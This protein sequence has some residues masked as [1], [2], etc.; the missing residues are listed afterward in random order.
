MQTANIDEALRTRHMVWQK[1]EPQCVYCLSFGVNRI[2]CLAQPAQESQL[3]GQGENGLNVWVCVYGEGGWV[4]VSLR[5]KALWFTWL[6]AA[7]KTSN[8]ARIFHRC[9]VKCRIIWI[10]KNR[11]HSTTLWPATQPKLNN[12][13]SFLN[14][15]SILET[16][17]WEVGFLLRGTVIGDPC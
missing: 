13:I 10:C 9:K 2:I 7:R 16:F 6:V 15:F 1:Y 12:V 4:D 5:F 8:H 17:P 3:T 14:I 11:G